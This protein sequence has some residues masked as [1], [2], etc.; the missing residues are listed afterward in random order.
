[1]NP[2]TVEYVAEQGARTAEQLE[3][4]PLETLEGFYKAINKP[5]NFPLVPPRLGGPVKILYPHFLKLRALRAWIGY[6]RLRGEPLD[7]NLFVGDE[8]LDTFQMRATDLLALSSK[9]RPEGTLPPPLRTDWRSFEQLFRTYLLNRRSAFSYTPL[10]YVIRENAVPADGALTRQYR[11]IDEDLVMT[12]S[13]GH[14][15]FS[16]D[17]NE[18]FDIFKRLIFDSTSYWQFAVS[19]DDTRDGRAAFLAVKAQAEGQS[20]IITQRAEAYKKISDAKFVGGSNTRY[21]FANYISDHQQGHNE[22]QR[23]GEPVPETKKVTD[24]LHGIV[25][26]ELRTAIVFVRGTPDLLGNFERCQQ[27]LNTVHLNLQLDAKKSSV[28]AVGTAPQG[29]PNAS[30]R[31]R[32]RR[33]DNNNP[34]KRARKAGGGRRDPNPKRN[35][36]RIR[37][38]HYSEE[39]WKKLSDAERS[40]VMQLRAAQKQ[41]NA[42]VSATTAEPSNNTAPPASNANATAHVAS[43]VTTNIAPT[44][45]EVRDALS[46]ASISPPPSLGEPRRS[47]RPSWFDPHTAVTTAPPVPATVSIANST[48]TV[49]AVG[50]SIPTR[51]VPID[52]SLP[53]HGAPQGTPWYEKDPGKLTKNQRNKRNKHLVRRKYL[54]AP[55]TLAPYQSDDDSDASARTNDD[56]SWEDPMEALAR[57]FKEGRAK[58]ISYSPKTD[59]EQRSPTTDNGSNTA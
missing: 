9:S 41:A 24:F 42:T 52:T 43:V 27:Y 12:Q 10:A 40:A 3:G 57:A 5:D 20:A 33:N 29:N 48:A 25:N 46:R 15:N 51:A 54:T 37:T 35:L 1:M 16:K 4:M 39:E 21:K 2:A 11:S 18:V 56:D 13:H 59:N 6:R 49:A 55:A 53:N 26:P 23:L 36:P 17:N 45:P 47:E 8:L 22:L 50:T 19:F 38:G 32:N 28:S 14:A 58:H 30:K 44:E 7:V 31:N 34:N